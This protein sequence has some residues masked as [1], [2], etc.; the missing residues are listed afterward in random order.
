MDTDEAPKPAYISGEL[1]AEM[2][3]T[4]DG[5]YYVAAA[6]P[7]GIHYVGFDDM[8]E[9]VMNSKE[10]KLYYDA[11][12]KASAGRSAVDGKNKLFTAYEEAARGGLMKDA[13]FVESTTVDG[14]PTKSDYSLH[15]IVT[16]GHTDT[17]LLEALCVAT[18]IKVSTDRDDDKAAMRFKPYSALEKELLESV[19]EV[20]L[21]NIGKGAA[22]FGIILRGVPATNIE[23]V[24]EVATATVSALGL[25][26]ATHLASVRPQQR[27]DKEGVYVPSAYTGAILLYAKGEVPDIVPMQISYKVKI[28]DATRKQTAYTGLGNLVVIDHDVC[29]VCGGVDR[30]VKGCSKEYENQRAIEKNDRSARNEAQKRECDMVR[31]RP[32]TPLPPPTA[33]ALT[34][35]LRTCCT[36]AQHLPAARERPRPEARDLPEEDLHRLQEAAGRHAVQEDQLQVHAMRSPAL[37]AEEG[38]APD[39]PQALGDKPEEEGRRVEAR[40]RD[41]TG[42]GLGKGMEKGEV[43][44]SKNGAIV[45]KQEVLMTKI[46]TN[47]QRDETHNRNFARRTGHD[48]DLSPD[49]TS[50]LARRRT[51]HDTDPSPDST[52]G[53][54]EAAEKMDDLGIIGETG[55]RPW[56]QCFDWKKTGDDT[57]PAEPWAREMCDAWGIEGLRLECGNEAIMCMGRATWAVREW[58][59]RRKDKKSPVPQKLLRRI[60]HTPGRDALL[61]TSVSKAADQY[62]MPYQR[63]FATAGEVATLWGSRGGAEERS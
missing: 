56:R 54:R 45:I 33:I 17:I 10:I 46:A 40:G 58:E 44:G 24:M 28:G 42:A 5:M 8:Q 7:F 9:G 26:G 3:A 61:P 51:G 52:P 53:R 62:Y 57:G 35:R 41:E 32:H 12:S 55:K 48:I 4:T 39:H 13:Q 63:R 38:D 18:D 1:Q 25:Q 60:L 21:L 6:I 34:N 29:K 31:A 47:I 11:N 16:L 22:S 27:K 59:A 2:A 15:R 30:H 43:R 37:R 23:V 50:G 36:G 14:K 19:G 20:M 49:P